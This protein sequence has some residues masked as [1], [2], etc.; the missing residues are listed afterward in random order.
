M[1]D[2]VDCCFVGPA[3]VLDVAVAEVFVADTDDEAVDFVV[4]VETETSRGSMRVNLT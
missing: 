4:D 1:E 3:D 2:D